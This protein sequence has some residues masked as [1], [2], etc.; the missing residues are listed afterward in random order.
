M[1]TSEG[2]SF[3]KHDEITKTING[4]K[5]IA[6][7]YNL[8]M[9]VL[10]QL[11]RSLEGRTN[12]RPNLSDLR[13]SGSLE[14]TADIVMFVHREEYYLS[15]LKPSKQSEIR[16]WENEMK[17]IRGK[18]QLIISKARDDETGDLEFKFDAEFGRFTEINGDC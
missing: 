11:N 9:V 6:K 18:S 17:M 8:L 16:E 14:Q 5:E 10:C 3:S 2:K 13:E 12:H 7:E 1:I 4:L 15:K